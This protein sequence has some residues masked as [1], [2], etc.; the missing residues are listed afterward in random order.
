MA[1]PP[2][3]RP[4]AVTG[5][6]AAGQ[7]PAREREDAGTRGTAPSQRRPPRWE[8]ARAGELFPA[9]L[10]H[11]RALLPYCPAQ[12]EPRQGSAGREWAPPGPSSPTFPD[13][14][15]SMAPLARTVLTPPLPPGRPLPP[16]PGPRMLPPRPTWGPRLP[17]GEGALARRERGGELRSGTSGAVAP[18]ERR[19]AELG[20]ASCERTALRQ[21]PARDGGH[22]GKCS[23]AWVSDCRSCYW[24]RECR[25]LIGLRALALG[26]SHLPG[27]WLLGNVLGQCV[28]HAVRAERP[29]WTVPTSALKI[30]GFI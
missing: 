28:D 14:L 5:R 1:G 3:R 27:R 8:E 17:E 21:P 10:A 19:G 20:P 29:D 7:L 22:H 15:G 12:P 13:S 9:G 18:E 24:L 25:V 16:R 2:S 26:A 23:P 11:L 30:P 6:R 4:R